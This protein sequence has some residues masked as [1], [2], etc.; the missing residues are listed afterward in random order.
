MLEL[1][2]MLPK[3]NEP[4]V[5]WPQGPS[6]A[7]V[8]PQQ[9][10]RSMIAS[11]E[12][13]RTQTAQSLADNSLQVIMEGIKPQELEPSPL[14]PDYTLKMHP[15]YLGGGG[16]GLVYK[17]AYF[18]HATVAVKKLALGSSATGGLASKAQ[19]EQFYNEV[20]IM[21]SW[22]HPN[23][24]SLIGAVMQSNC[25]CLVMEYVS[26]ALSSKLRQI[27]SGV[28]EALLEQAGGPPQPQPQSLQPPPPQQQ[29]WSPVHA[30]LTL[31]GAQLA[32]QLL[33]M[34]LRLHIVRGVLAGLQFL[35]AKRVAHR[36]LKPA[37][38][39]L[40]DNWT[41]RLIDFGLSK[42]MSAHL[43]SSGSGKAGQV[44]DDS[45]QAAATGGGGGVDPVGMAV[46]ATEGTLIYMSPELLMSPQQRIDMFGS[47]QI[48]AFACDMWSLGMLLFEMAFLLPPYSE[49]RCL[50]DDMVRS[51][52]MR[53][54][55]PAL[56][57]YAMGALRGG[58]AAA[59]AVVPVWLISLMKQ[60]W[61]QD[62]ADRPKLAA[63]ISLFKQHCP[64]DVVP[65]L[66]P[67]SQHGVGCSCCCC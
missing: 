17:A 30:H 10:I 64:E 52:I 56:P 66:L 39:L 63:I 14:L 33:P 8:I 32:E 5:I 4:G 40:A 57:A 65:P 67:P 21:K 36:D 50:P 51:A 35:Q 16:F 28:P 1:E 60:C 27:H 46:L 44:G 26:T 6:P 19:L 43:K 55:L 41:P 23:I 20:K 9:Q 38:I 47:D 22:P 54:T 11:V 49:L 45:K 13:H 25:C 31:A 15:S 37:N 24:I 34:S 48:D 18:Q 7:E 3:V 29:R 59:A 12:L 2:A 62:P 58:D 53:A 61:K 42:L